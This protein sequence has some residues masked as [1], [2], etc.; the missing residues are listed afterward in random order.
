MIP[1]KEL[2]FTKTRQVAFIDY[3]AA[4]YYR[5]N[6]RSKQGQQQIPNYIIRRE[7]AR[8][9]DVPGVYRKRMRHFVD[10]LV[11]GSHGFVEKYLNDLRE[12]G[13]YIR[14]KNPLKAKSGE[15]MILREQRGMG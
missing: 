4:I 7:E 10:G 2:M 13:F 15:G 8:G 5:G 9:F 6:V 1:L 3:R 11:V 14:R 12:G